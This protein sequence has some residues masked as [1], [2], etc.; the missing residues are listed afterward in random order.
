[1]APDSV[2]LPE[3]RRLAEAVK[4][5][6]AHA[7][8]FLTTATPDVVLALLDRIDALE[9]GLVQVGWQGI[10]AENFFVL[11]DHPEDHAEDLADANLRPIYRLADPGA[12]AGEPES[13]ETP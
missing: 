1:M 8:A 2:D 6:P 11:S 9:A 13:E 4:E 3:L 12:V 10:E 5:G 7:V